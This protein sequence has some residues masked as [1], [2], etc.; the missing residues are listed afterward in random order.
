M[1]TSVVVTASTAGVVSNPNA[2]ASGGNQGWDQG[3]KVLEEAVNNSTTAIGHAAFDL[4][5]LKIKDGTTVKIGDQTYTFALG[6]KS[7][8]KGSANVVDLTDMETLPEAGSD[9]WVKVV[10]RLTAAAAGNKMVSVTSASTKVSTLGSGEGDGTNILD[11]T[12]PSVVLLT[13]KFGG[14]DRDKYDVFGKIYDKTAG[15][16]MRKVLTT[17]LA[18]AMALSLA[19]PAFA[20][21]TPVRPL[22]E[23]SE[24]SFAVELE[25]MIYTPTIRVQVSDSGSVYVNPSKSAVAGTMTKAL[26]GTIDLDYSFKGKTL[27]STPILIRSDTENALKVSATGTAT[28]PTGSEVKLANAKA[29]TASDGKV[30]FLQVGGSTTALG[31]SDALKTVTESDGT[32]TPGITESNIARHWMRSRR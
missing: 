9:D 6:S 14:L 18:G 8:F 27:I 12:D 1:D 7:Q 19:A 25:G 2:E 24:S 26:D 22:T 29:T 31:D 4:A 17:A 32:K 5:D 15:A 3:W 20:D 28:V 16:K 13:E 30:V 21:V 23:T 10:G 11:N